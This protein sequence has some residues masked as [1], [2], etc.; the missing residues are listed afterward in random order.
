MQ[1]G[2]VAMGNYCIK[3]EWAGNAPKAVYCKLC[4]TKLVEQ[5]EQAC[6][7]CGKKFTTP[8]NTSFCDSC[9]IRLVEERKNED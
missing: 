4:G 5:E 2:G 7:R 9:G 3:C 1:E 6:G 8:S